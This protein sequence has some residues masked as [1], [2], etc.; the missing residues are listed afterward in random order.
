MSALSEQNQ[1]TQR[2]QWISRCGPKQ[3]RKNYKLMQGTLNFNSSGRKNLSSRFFLLR[4]RRSCC[5]FTLIELLVSIAIIALLTVLI[6]A[7]AKSFLNSGKSAKSTSNLRQI[8]LASVAFSNDN[9][10]LLPPITALQPKNFNN[11]PN[12]LGI[13]DEY[14][15]GDAKIDPTLPDH[16]YGYGMNL[17]LSPSA[18]KTSVRGQSTGGW[19]GASAPRFTQASCYTWSNL[20]NPSLTIFFTP[21]NSLPN[22]D[23]L[24]VN[25]FAEY[26]QVSNADRHR[27]GFLQAV[28]CDGSIQSIELEELTRKSPRSIHWQGGI[29]SVATFN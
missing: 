11:K 9:N 29:E 18:T 12:R 4:Q 24:V 8:F 21:T 20:S 22:S 3:V 7:G 10:N 26:N 13:L 14:G 5:A 23:P 19:G 1:V 15:V 17:N 25:Y 2:E 16:V 27:K 6:F 28:M